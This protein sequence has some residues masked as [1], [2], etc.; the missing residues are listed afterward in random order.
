M[1]FIYEAHEGAGSQQ[2]RQV[3]DMDRT[4]RKKNNDAVKSNK[5]ERQKK[6]RG[7]RKQIA[8]MK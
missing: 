7:I 6:Q 1:L 8:R 5:I 2:F 4:G 3:E